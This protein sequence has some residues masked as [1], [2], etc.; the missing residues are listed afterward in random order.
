MLFNIGSYCSGVKLP[1]Y[2]VIL[3]ASIALIWSSKAIDGKFKRATPAAR[4]EYKS[5]EANAH[6]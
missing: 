1:R 5:G 4:R 2:A 6:V 3:L